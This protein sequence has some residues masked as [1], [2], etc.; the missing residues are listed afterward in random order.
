M[1]EAGI[2]TIEW[3]TMGCNSPELYEV[4]IGYKFEDKDS[5]SYGDWIAVNNEGASYV[6]TSGK[7]FKISLRAIPEDD[8]DEIN[9]PSWIDVSYKIDDRR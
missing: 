9:I 5:W 7:L 6:K 3:I 2:K 8:L 1:K 4:R